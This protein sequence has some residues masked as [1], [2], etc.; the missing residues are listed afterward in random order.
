MDLSSP[1]PHGP[2]FDAD[3]GNPT[4]ID[5]YYYN[6]QPVTPAKVRP[7]LSATA[8]G[9]LPD[10]KCARKARLSDAGDNSKIDCRDTT[11]LISDRRTRP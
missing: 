8:R 1:W 3:H 9:S 4:D 11:Y 6:W 2:Q 5:Y 10:P 7:R